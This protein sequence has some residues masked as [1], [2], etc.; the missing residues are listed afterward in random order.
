MTFIVHLIHR[1]LFPSNTISQNYIP[2]L[3]QAKFTPPHRFYTT[4]SRGIF[5]ETLRACT[6]HTSTQLLREVLFVARDK[7]FCSG[8]ESHFKKHV[9]ISVG[10][11]GD[12]H[13]FAMF[14]PQFSTS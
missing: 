5:Q 4:S 3:K 14:R 2:S 6:A 1:M 10:K 7:D 13:H 11:Y 12:S 8:R 9:I